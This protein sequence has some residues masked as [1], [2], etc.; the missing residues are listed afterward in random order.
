M[1]RLFRVALALLPLTGC[2]DD[3]I[4]AVPSVSSTA[5]EPA[6]AN[7]VFG[8]VAIQSGQDVNGNEPAGTNCTSGGTKITSGIDDNND[9]TLDDAEVHATRYVCNA[10][11]T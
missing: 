8:G 9:R 4:D 5:E 1:T 3:G 7:C 6:G 11:S 2:G 10:P